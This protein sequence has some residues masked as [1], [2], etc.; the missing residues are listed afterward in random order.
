M[1]VIFSKAIQSD[2]GWN[3]RP[4]VE[5]GVIPAAGDVK[6]TSR[7]RVPAFGAEAEMKM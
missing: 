2:S 3:F 1:G 6:A 4:Q 5:L 7:A